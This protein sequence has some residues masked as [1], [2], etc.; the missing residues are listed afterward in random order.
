[1]VS[2]RVIING[3]SITRLG[4]PYNTFLAKD[5]LL[6]FSDIFFLMTPNQQKPEYCKL[7]N[8]SHDKT[9]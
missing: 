9:S 3:D 7:I 2:Y 8:P 4:Y 6:G 5:G 1:M